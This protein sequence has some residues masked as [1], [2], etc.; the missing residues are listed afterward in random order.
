MP[1]PRAQLWT[2]GLPIKV[3]WCVQPPRNGGVSWMLSSHYLSHV[4]PTRQVRVSRFSWRYSRSQWAVP[5][6]LWRSLLR[7]GSAHVR[8]EC[9][10]ECQNR[11]QKECH[12]TCQ[13]VCQNRCQI[14]CQKECQS[15]CQKECQIECQNMCS[16]YTSRW[17]VRNYVRVKITRRLFSS[18]FLSFCLSFFLSLSLSPV[19]IYILI[20]LYIYTYIYIYIYYL[21]VHMGSIFHIYNY[22]YTE[23]RYS[24]DSLKSLLNALDL[25]IVGVF[26]GFWTPFGGFC[27]WMKTLRILW[28]TPINAPKW[29]FG[30]YHFKGAAF[31]RPRGV[32]SL[33]ILCC[34]IY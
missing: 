13:K 32:H 15:L 19:Y 20:Y 23:R 33:M 7:S 1:W 5:T 17:Y 30:V 10:K 11:C 16:I 14:E 18:F 3:N 31:K 25:D 21:F 8:I 24:G 29:A 2:I 27:R 4:F 34:I 28:S 22:I 6:A 9:Q 12:H 26:Q